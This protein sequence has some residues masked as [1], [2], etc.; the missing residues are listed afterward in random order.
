MSD[1]PWFRVAGVILTILVFFGI[2]V[3][4]WRGS[5]GLSDSKKPC[6]TCSKRPSY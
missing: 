3:L 6:P 5:V 4:L 1:R 2:L